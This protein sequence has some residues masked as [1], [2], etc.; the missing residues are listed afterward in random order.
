MRSY[1]LLIFFVAF[2]TISIDAKRHRPGKPQPTLAGSIRSYLEENDRWVPS[3]QRRRNV[4]RSTGFSPPPI[5]NNCES[6]CRNSSTFYNWL[7]YWIDLHL[8]LEEAGNWTQ[9][10]H[11]MPPDAY[12]I[13]YST[14]QGG[15]NNASSATQTIFYQYSAIYGSLAQKPPGFTYVTMSLTLDTDDYL[16]AFE[17]Y[18]SFNHTEEIT[19]LL[20]GIPPTHKY[21][22]VYNT[23]FI[24]FVPPGEPDEGKLF[25][26]RETVDMA[27]VLLH[28]GYTQLA[29]LPVIDCNQAIDKWKNP[30]SN[31][32]LF[33]QNF[34]RSY[35]PPP[36]V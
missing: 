2:L 30:Y 36:E 22:E 33:N 8:E 21:F 23:L 1:I 18:N 13:F 12:E 9:L 20:P 32:I 35:P 29:N 4:E 11:T 19:F 6:P 25:S 5:V 31:A 15:C 3:E 27:G 28:A 34:L 16:A 17:F 7:F 14:M 26:E 10:I 24:E